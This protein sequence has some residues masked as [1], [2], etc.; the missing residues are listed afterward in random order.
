MSRNWRSGVKEILR[1]VSGVGGVDVMVVLK[2]SAE[3][4]IQGDNSTS[5]SVTTEKG[6]RNRPVR[7]KHG[8]GT[9]HGT[10]GKR[11]RAG[12]GGGKEVYPEIAGIVISASGGGQPSVQAEISRPWRH[13]SGFRRIK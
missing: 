1:G 10:D 9:Q 8:P 12:A 4:V 3:K 11:K 7:G 6:E 2:S 13:Y 5:K